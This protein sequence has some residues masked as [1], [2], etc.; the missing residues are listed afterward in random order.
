ME[1]RTCG[2]RG[3][4]INGFPSSLN[5]ALPAVSAFAPAPTAARRAKGKKSGKVRRGPA[6]QG[7]PAA[8]RAQSRNVQRHRRAA[9]A[10]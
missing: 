3:A 2:T 6:R 1:T 7:P 9:A 4:A 8:S 10:R 5:R